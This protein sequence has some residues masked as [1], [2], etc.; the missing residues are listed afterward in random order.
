MIWGATDFSADV[1]QTGA[2]LMQPHF[3]TGTSIIPSSSSTL[4]T[5]NCPPLPPM[6]LLLTNGNNNNMTSANFQTVNGPLL[7]DH[8]LSSSTFTSAAGAMAPLGTGSAANGGTSF[9][10]LTSGGSGGGNSTTTLGSQQLGSHPT[11]RALS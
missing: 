5:S 3:V 8:H 6:G 4:T 10:V 2:H 11:T 1:P 9:S 7:H